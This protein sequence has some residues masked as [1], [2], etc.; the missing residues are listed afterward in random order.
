M[1]FEPR[2]RRYV[3]LADGIVVA[4]VVAAVVAAGLSLRGSPTPPHPVLTVTDLTGA[5]GGSFD[6]GI[7]LAGAAN[8]T[9]V[10]VGGIGV[11]TKDPEFSL[12]VL[13]LLQPSPHGPQVTNLTAAV[14]DE[15]FAGGVYAIGWNGTAW[16]IAGQAAWGGGNF[17]SAVSWQAGYFRNVTAPIYPYFAGGGVF[18]LGWN[19]TAWLFGGNSSS[20]IALVAV[21][22]STVTDLT[23][24]V[25]A[26]ERSDWI[27]SVH[28]NGESWLV[29]GEHVFGELTGRRYSDLLPGSPFAASGVYASGWN[30]SAWVVGGGAG[31]LVAVESGTWRTV[32][33]LPPSFDQ[34]ALMVLPTDHGWFVAGKGLDEGTTVGELLFLY[35]SPEAPVVA[36]FGA[37]VPDAFGAGEIQGGLAAPAFGPNAYLLVGDG[38]YDNAT[39]Y[40]VGAAAL[41]TLTGA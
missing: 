2:P 1:G 40:G 21:A 24:V 11:Y 35:G 5:L 8:A 23:P 4:L 16:V 34:A 6:P 10:L 31:Q 7:I 32:A 27:Q 17:G 41:A 37:L 3:R 30:G 29:G 38:G 18:A 25:P 22:G 39:G 13:A 36:D 33:G 19:G 9:A 26:R 28:W 15:F 14:N 20:G 12:P